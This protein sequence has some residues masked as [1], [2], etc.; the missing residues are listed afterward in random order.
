[1]IFH[2]DLLTR[3]ML[4]NLKQWQ[5]LYSLVTAIKPEDSL[6]ISEENMKICR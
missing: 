4:M 6:S 5:S 2:D 1:M 3:M